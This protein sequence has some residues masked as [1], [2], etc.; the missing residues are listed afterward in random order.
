VALPQRLPAPGHLLLLIKLAELIP[1]GSVSTY[2]VKY[3][4]FEAAES[5]SFFSE[6]AKDACTMPGLS[7]LYRKID[8]L[9]EDPLCEASLSLGHPAG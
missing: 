4:T 7:F 5:S 1:T 2:G 8:A 9:R 3:F 6:S